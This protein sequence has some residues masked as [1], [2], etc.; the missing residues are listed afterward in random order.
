[1]ARARNIK[2]ALFKNE[3][4][5]VADPLCTLTF[6]G[7]WMLADR[8][9]RLEDRPLRI[10]AETFPY[11]DGINLDDL[12]NWLDS[13]DFILRYE[14]NGKRYIQ[15]LNFAKHQNPHKNEVLSEIPPP[16]S[17]RVPKK[18]VHAPSD[19]EALGLIPDS[20]NLIP[21][22]LL[23]IAE[24]PPTPPP[25]GE[26]MDNGFD[27]FWLEYPKKSGKQTAMK[28]WWKLKPSGQLL[29]EIMVGLQRYKSSEQWADP[30][31][32]HDPATW[33]NGRRWEDEVTPGKPKN[34]LNL[35]EQKYT[36]GINT[37]DHSF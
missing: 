25:A 37:N 23:L 14:I 21:D 10:K 22:S 5:G 16:D 20:F 2:P 13:E 12:L 15:V 31:Y 6:Q 1:M 11:R 4:L 3:I 17:G 32:I 24:G 36:E 18:S 8:D 27:A 19:S 9:G 34:S 30:K 7:L 29:L 28:A 35:S 26:S 33:I